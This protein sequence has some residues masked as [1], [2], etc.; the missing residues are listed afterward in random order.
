METDNTVLRLAQLLPRD[1]R[2]SILDILIRNYGPLELAKILK[3]PSLT[4]E[5]W[6]SGGFPDDAE[7]ARI[8]SSALQSA[9][10]MNLLAEFFEEVRLFAEKLG[11]HGR[12]MRINSFM[13]G[14]DAKS[15][16]VLQCLMLKRHA[17]IRELADLTEASSDMEVLIR[18]REAINGR[19]EAVLGAPLITFERC[20]IDPVTCEKVLFSW[21]LSEDLVEF[22]CGDALLDVFDDGA[23]L[24]VVA[25]LPSKSR[26]DLE[27]EVRNSLLRIAARG[28]RKEVPL[29]ISVEDVVAKSCNNGVLEVRLK[30]AVET[31]DCED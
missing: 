30:K 7:T 14:L 19:A 24:R 28:Y 29:L 21:W 10:V 3:H 25:Y 26:E 23:Y 9:E 5:K 17:S 4:V 16:Q 2:R 15:K 22:D 27:V 20:R 6:L 31:C 12:Q 18:L 13:E 8:L 11:P 1:V